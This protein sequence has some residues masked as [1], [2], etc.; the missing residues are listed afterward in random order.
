[1]VRKGGSSTSKVDP[2][3][4]KLLD[5]RVEEMRADIK[6]RSWDSQGS[7]T[8]DNVS[9]LDYISLGQPLSSGS[10]C[11]SAASVRNKLIVGTTQKEVKSFQ[12]MKY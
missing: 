12:I 2:T 6:D 1:M 9:I 10:E 4:R 3:H 8:I 5:I 7:V 11:C